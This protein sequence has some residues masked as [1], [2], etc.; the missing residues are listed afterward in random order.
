MPL[1]YHMT[2]RLHHRDIVEDEG[3]GCRAN[4]LPRL[5]AVIIN[6]LTTTPAVDQVPT[7]C[8]YTHAHTHT[9][10]MAI[11][12]F[13]LRAPPSGTLSQISSRTRLSV[14]TVLDV[15]IC[16]LHA[17]GP[18]GFLMTFA[19]Y[20]SIYLHTPVQWIFLPVNLR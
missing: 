10:L 18:S 8:M 13:Q 5:L 1:T 15:Y 12:P 3:V 20:Q 2:E 9:H 14:Q 4:Q 7:I 6:I 19:L 11:G 17:L 16:S